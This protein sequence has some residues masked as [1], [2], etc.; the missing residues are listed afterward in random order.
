MSAS[1][2]AL[3]VLIAIGGTETPSCEKSHAAFQQITTDVRDAIAVYDRCV[4]GSNGR[5]NCSE[6]FEDV[7]IAQDWF[8]MI[9][10]ELA[11]GCR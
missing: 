3:L 2:T 5:A 9:V 10:A 1:A 4:S 8:E 11:N 7:Q 6:E